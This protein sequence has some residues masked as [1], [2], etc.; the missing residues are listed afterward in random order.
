MN[1]KNLFFDIIKAF[2][3]PKLTIDSEIKVAKTNNIFYLS[4]FKDLELTSKKPPAIPSLLCS[5]QYGIAILP[6]PCSSDKYFKTLTSSTHRK[7]DKAKRNNYDFKRIN[8]NDYLDEV[9]QM[10]GSIPIGH[11]QI[12]SKLLTDALQS[13]SNPALH[14]DKHDY[15][16]FGIFT[17]DHLVAYAGCLVAEELLL[18]LT[19]FVHEQYNSDCIVPYLITSIADYKYQNYSDVKYFLYG[20]Y[21]GASPSLSRFKKRHRFNPHSIS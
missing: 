7:I 18:L 11:G 21:Y 6:M 9:A 4:V 5:L 8:Y 13:F 19:V 16:Y 14:I 3:T 12:E 20:N 1:I 2:K 17:E 15:P 10:H